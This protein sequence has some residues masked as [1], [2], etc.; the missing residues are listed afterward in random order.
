MP[1]DT[2]EVRALWGLWQL[3]VVWSSHET[4]KLNQNSLHSELALPVGDARKFA[5]VNLEQ[6]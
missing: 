2:L 3:L 6:T 5:E 1:L 4:T